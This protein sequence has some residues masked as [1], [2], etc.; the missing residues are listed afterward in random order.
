MKRLAGIIFVTVLGIAF[1]AGANVLLD[2]SGKK[3]PRII[4]AEKFILRDENGKKRGALQM[5]DQGPSALSSL[6]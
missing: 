4:E 1:I 2:S 3:Q 6:D 5:T